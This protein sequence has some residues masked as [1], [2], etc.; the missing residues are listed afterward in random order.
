MEINPEKVALKIGIA[1]GEKLIKEMKDGS[2]VALI[3]AL[4]FAS[5]LDFC[6]LILLCQIPVLGAM[7]KITASVVLMII[8]WSVGSFLKIKIRIILFIAGLF[9]SV[10]VIATLPL[11]LCVVLWAN[12]KIKKR[13]KEARSDLEKYSV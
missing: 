10:P 13:A 9:E 4:L 1:L 8:Y 7:I 6:D 3:I 12:H 11:N 2:S 5:F